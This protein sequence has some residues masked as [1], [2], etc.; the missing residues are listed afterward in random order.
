MFSLLGKK[1][2]ER[3][4][5]EIDTILAAVFGKT[6]CEGKGLKVTIEN[7]AIQKSLPNMFDGSRRMP[8]GFELKL[9]GDS[10][11]ITGEKRPIARMT[12]D[13]GLYLTD[14]KKRPAI[15][16]FAQSICAGARLIDPNAGLA[17][18]ERFFGKDTRS[19]VKEISDKAI[20]S[21]DSGPGEFGLLTLPIKKALR[22][23]VADFFKA[24]HGSQQGSA[25]KDG[26]PI[27]EGSG[28]FLAV[29][30]HGGYRFYGKDEKKI[31]GFFDGENLA[32]TDVF[33]Y[34]AFAERLILEIAKNPRKQ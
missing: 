28:D 34:K 10:V 18:Y 32:F 31:I 15:R 8:A 20:F 27:F 22:G 1:D 7:E 5:N 14:A 19:R 3:F 11:Y 2:E 21:Y 16:R 25:V 26:R 33:K 13:G 12:R 4:P 17:L 29:G 9:D 23:R 6:E 30:Q 24:A